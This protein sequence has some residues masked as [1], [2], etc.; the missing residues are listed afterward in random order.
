MVANVSKLLARY[1]CVTHIIQA[2][3]G[4]DLF[5]GSEWEMGQIL[6]ET[7]RRVWSSLTSRLMNEKPSSYREH[8]NMLLMQCDSYL[9]MYSSRSWWCVF[10]GS[11]YTWAFLQWWTWYKQHFTRTYLRTM[12]APRGLRIISSMMQVM[13]KWWPTWEYFPWEVSQGDHNILY[14]ALK[15]RQQK[16]KGYKLY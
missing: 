16:Q 10:E 13:A 14:D 3:L 15:S 6:P 4:T 11:S 7:G 5:N 12:C 8:C 1:C 2:L 9:V